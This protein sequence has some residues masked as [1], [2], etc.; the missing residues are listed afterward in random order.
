ME[1]NQT[2]F[3][4]C[5]SLPIPSIVVLSFQATL[6]FFPLSFLFSA[7]LVMGALVFDDRDT[8]ITYS[9]DWALAGSD[10][11]FNG[12]TSWTAT[13]GATAKLTFVGELFLMLSSQSTDFLFSRLQH[14]GVWD[15]RRRN[16]CGNT[17]LLLP[18]GR[19]DPRR[20]SGEPHTREPVQ[21]AVLPVPGPIKW[22]T[23]PYH[24]EPGY[25]PAVP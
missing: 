21:P 2:E 1:A 23:Y 19:H 12:T 16:P 8:A 24:H 14:I 3:E 4:P 5:C 11:E 17:D 13:E 18:G 22:S 10:R 9:A 20:L 25:S 6:L 7:F 15:D